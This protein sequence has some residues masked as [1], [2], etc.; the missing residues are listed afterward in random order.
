MRVAEEQ[1]HVASAINLRPQN[2]RFRAFLPGNAILQ[3][4]DASLESLL[5]GFRW[6]RIDSVDAL[7]G[8]RGPYDPAARAFAL[9]SHPGDRLGWKNKQICT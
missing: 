4:I 5:A 7:K 9:A 8:L 1:Q 6:Q 3:Q 2:E